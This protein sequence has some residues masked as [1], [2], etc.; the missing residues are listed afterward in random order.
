MIS[1]NKRMLFDYGYLLYPYPNFY[2]SN[3]FLERRF[4]AAGIKSTFS[5]LPKLSANEA[6]DALSK[7]EGMDSTIAVL[8]SVMD[9]EGIKLMSVQNLN[10]E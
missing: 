6:V 5:V 8:Q 3:W 10:L 1:V 7:W 2:T 4:S 9:S